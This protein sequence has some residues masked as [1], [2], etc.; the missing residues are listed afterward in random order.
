MDLGAGLGVLGFIA[1]KAGAKKVYVVE[2][3]P[4]VR[5]AAN[6]AS[7]NGLSDKVECVQ[8]KVE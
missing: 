3:K 2:P 6:V 1:A 5:T 7:D 8:E 4:A